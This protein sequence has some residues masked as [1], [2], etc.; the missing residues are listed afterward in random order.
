MTGKTMSKR[1]VKRVAR[2]GRREV[3][4]EFAFTEDMIPSQN[5]SSPAFVADARREA[6]ALAKGM[7][8]PNTR[9]E[10]WR[11]TDLRRLD[12][13][14]FR[15]PNPVDGDSL[16]AV[17]GELLLPLIGEEHG[18][19]VVLQPGK[20]PEVRLDS[21]LAS[22]GVV[23]NDLES[24]ERSHPELLARIRGAAVKPEEGKFAA[25]T[26]ALGRLGVLLYVPSGVDVQLPLH[27]VLW[28]PG[29]GLAHFSHILVYLEDGAQATFVHE[30]ASPD[31]NGQTLSASI[32]EGYVGRN[33]NLTFVE[34]QSLGENVYNFAHE[35]IRVARD[36]A[37]DWIYGALGTRLTKAF[38]DL[39]L[40]GEGSHGRMSGFFFTNGKQHLDLDTQQNHHAPHT[41]SDLLFKGALKENSRSVWQGMIYV[42][43][44]AQK[45]DG[46]QA[47]RNLVLDRT[48]RADSIPG[49]EILADDVRCTHGATVGKVDPEHMFY[50]Q[51]R[52]VP[53]HEA[54]RLIVEGFFRPI[55]DR[56]PYQGVRERLLR[57]I[58]D[59][60]A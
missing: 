29:A 2:R 36:G 24:A 54:R 49:L 44:G 12:A 47:N 48:A 30:A 3:S 16:A 13:A 9:M 58:R 32:L 4:R 31:E 25:L 34:L 59:K 39:D 41:T 38:S 21:A 37:V 23:F 20:A 55:M 10:A 50:L 52:G 22:R 27:S 35:R 42:A 6:W 56:I 15:L 17:P 1:T 28:A 43:P 11:R 26:S 53:E 18:G 8:M 45:T 46:Y 60:L 5:G 40:E 14:G 51:A 7:P 19:L 57:S 33:A